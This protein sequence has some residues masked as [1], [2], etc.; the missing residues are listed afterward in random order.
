MIFQPGLSAVETLPNGTTFTN[1][2]HLYLV[3]GSGNDSVTF[4]EPLFDIT[5]SSPFGANDYWDAGGGTNSVTVNLA[6]DTGSVNASYYNS[7]SSYYVISDP[8]GQLLG[9]NNVQ[10]FNITGG[11]GND[12][13]IGGSGTNALNGGGGNDTLVGGPNADRLSGGAGND[14]LIGGGGADILSGGTGNNTFVYNAVTNSTSTAFDTITDFDTSSD[15]FQ[16]WYS[17]TAID[18]RSPRER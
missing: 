4:N 9:L 3:T 16:L 1:I 8:D 14:I 17:V 18:A 13:L 7:Y 12:T 15:V 2:E 6:A 10:N 5:N 11:S